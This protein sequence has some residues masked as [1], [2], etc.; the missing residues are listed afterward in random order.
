MNEIAR[1]EFLISRVTQ[2]ILCATSDLRLVFYKQQKE[3]EQSRPLTVT[4][5]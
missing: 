4:N 1:S 2:Y 5:N 3:A